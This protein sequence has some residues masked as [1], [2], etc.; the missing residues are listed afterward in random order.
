[1]EKFDNRKL[2]G[3]ITEKFGTLSKFAKAME[4]SRQLLHLRLKTGS[5]RQVEIIKALEILEINNVVQ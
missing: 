4:M 1:M 3:K 5:W 2:R